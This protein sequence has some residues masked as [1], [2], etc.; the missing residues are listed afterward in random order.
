MLRSKPAGLGLMKSTC[1]TTLAA[2]TL[3]ASAAAQDDKAALAALQ[4]IDAEIKAGHFDLARADVDSDGD[5]DVFALM[6]GKSGYRGSGGATLF[7]LR[8]DKGT[9]AKAGG[10]KVVNEPVYLRAAKHHGLHDLLVTVS[11][12]GAK[13][14]LAALAFDDQGS[15]TEGKRGRTP[16]TFG[17]F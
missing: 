11:G 7:V 12:G 5:V 13:P 16:F 17:P 2:F 3:L 6:N 8:N 9:L 10:I 1:L 14:G 15:Q 4:S